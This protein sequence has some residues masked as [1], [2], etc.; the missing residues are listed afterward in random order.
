[1]TSWSRQ[2][3]RGWVPT[4]VARVFQQELLHRPHGTAKLI[5]LDAGAVYPPHRHPDRT[6]YAFVVHG[7]CELTVDDE[8]ISAAPG[9]FVSFPAR[10]VHALANAGSTPAVLLVGALAEETVDAES[11]T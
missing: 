6:E 5:R 9:D 3:E 1:M 10:V 8:V 7:R 11:P 2:D 4:P